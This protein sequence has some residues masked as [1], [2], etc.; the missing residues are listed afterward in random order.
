VHTVCTHKHHTSLTLSIIYS[1]TASI[2]HTK[3]LEEVPVGIVEE[4]PGILV[5]E[6]EPKVEAQECP[7][8]RPSSF[9]KGEL[10]HRTPYVL[11]CWGPSASEGPQKQDL[12]VFLQYNV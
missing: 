11:Q 12:T 1:H 4:L 6:G 7:D 9:K 2:H 8:H 5:E 3:L 10:W